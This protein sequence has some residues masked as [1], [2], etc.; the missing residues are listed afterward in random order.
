MSAESN[1]KNLQKSIEELEAELHATRQQLSSQ[2]QQIAQKFGLEFLA[3]LDGSPNAKVV[4]TPV[5]EK[6]VFTKRALAVSFLFPM[7]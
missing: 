6:L 7:A 1:D 2:R 3:V 4:F 5:V